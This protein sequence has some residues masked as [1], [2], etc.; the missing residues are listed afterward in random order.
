MTPAEFQTL[1]KKA[2]IAQHGLG[3]TCWE[4]QLETYTRLVREAYRAELLAG[5]AITAAKAVNVEPELVAIEGMPQGLGN[6]P[7]I[8]AQW[9]A[10]KAAS[11]GDYGKRQWHSVGAW[12]YEGD[13]IAVISDAVQ[14]Q[15]QGEATQLMVNGRNVF[16]IDPSFVWSYLKNTSHFDAELM[17]DSW[18]ALVKVAKAAHPQATEPAWQPI[19]TAPTSGLVLLTVVDAAGERRTF[20]GE[21]SFTDGRLEWQITTGWPGF[22]RLRAAWK[23]IGWMPL[24]APKEQDK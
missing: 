6:E 13:A 4:G 12:L 1:R 18:D 19:E 15:A 8:L 11:E 3:Y 20:C 14:P 10:V 23:A 21:A 5:T 2:N 22:T 7:E 16:E 17:R 9:D 24:P